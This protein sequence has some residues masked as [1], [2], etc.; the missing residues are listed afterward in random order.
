[1]PTRTGIVF[2]NEVIANGGGVSSL[3]PREDDGR[4]RRKRPK[5]I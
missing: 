3:L 2:A 1:M 5:R 4:D